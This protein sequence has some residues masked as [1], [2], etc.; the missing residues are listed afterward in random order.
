MPISGERFNGTLVG[1]GGLVEVGDGMTVSVAVG[2]EVTAP[3]PAWTGVFPPVEMNG[4][5]VGKVMGCSVTGAQD[6]SRTAINIAGMILIKDMAM[7][8]PKDTRPFAR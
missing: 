5:Y 4:S 7:I 3:L 8:L 2:V 1:V 6:V